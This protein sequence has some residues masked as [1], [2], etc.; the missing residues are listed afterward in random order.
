MYVPLLPG[1]TEIIA[2]PRSKFV[3]PMEEFSLH[4]SSVAECSVRIDSETQFSMKIL[5]SYVPI[6]ADC[7][8]SLSTSLVNTKAKRN[9]GGFVSSYTFWL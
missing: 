4:F 6:Y 3:K 7:L 9:L 2:H 5:P 8:G 1:M